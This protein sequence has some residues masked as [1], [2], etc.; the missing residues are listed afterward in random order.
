M[1]Y[2]ENRNNTTF[3]IYGDCNQV[4][5]FCSWYPRI[6]FK[7]D[8]L[9]NKI[10][11]LKEISLQW[12]E[13]TMSPY[14]FD[15]LFY[16]RSN[17]TE[18]INLITN[19]LKIADYNFAS[20]LAWNIDCYHFAFM[21]HKK[22]KANIFWWSDDALKLKSKW[23]L[24]LIKLWKASKIRLVHIIQNSNLDDL[25][26]FVY[27]VKK[28]FPWVNLIEFKYIQYFWNKNNLWEIPFYKNSYKI[29]N[30]AFNLCD[31]LWIDFIINGVPLCYLDKKF[32]KKTAS[33]YNKNNKEEMKEYSTIKLNKCIYCKY[34]KNCIGIRQDYIILN[35]DDE[36][37]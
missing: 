21:S 11:W 36:F 12:W 37:K 6:D 20:K 34:S 25:F 30:R 9:K 1:W 23:V 5:P 16:A 35:W 15:I 29:M 17:W 18:Y 10:K 8:D 7:L 2:I 28:R 26:E 31:K 13:P 4:C 3:N 22:D 14:L 32:H 27:F 19:W 24:N 33:Y